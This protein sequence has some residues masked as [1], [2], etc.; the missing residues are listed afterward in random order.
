M[1]ED[2]LP[3]GEFS[4]WLRLARSALAEGRDVEVPCGACTACCTSSY[5]VHIGPEETRTLERV[6]AE[7]LF[8]APGEPTGNVLMGFDEK[9]TAPCWST[10]HAPSTRIA[11]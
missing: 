11:P 2:A 5:F 6:P 1:S 10:A 7:L 9:G 4:S 3:A 8:P